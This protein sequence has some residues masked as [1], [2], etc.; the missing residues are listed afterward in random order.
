MRGEFHMSEFED[1]QR[2][3]PGLSPFID[4]GFIKV[5][6]TMTTLPDQLTVDQLEF[7]PDIDT[8]GK[9]D[10]EKLPLDEINRRIA[11]AFK[12]D[13]YTWQKEKGIKVKYKGRAEGLHKVLYQCAS[14]GR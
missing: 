7:L 14:C 2:S 3:I 10:L 12:Y 11:E 9:E 8:L 5:G 6:E 1:K 4:S 13:E